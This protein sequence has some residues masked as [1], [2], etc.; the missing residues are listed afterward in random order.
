MSCAGLLQAI[1]QINASACPVLA[2]DIPSGSSADTGAAAAPSVLAD[3]TISFITA[4]TGLHTGAGVSCAGVRE[5]AALGVPEHMYVAQGIPLLDWNV[6]T[7][8]ALDANTYKH[9]QGHVVIAGGDMSMPGAVVMAS[10]AALRAG[11]GMVTAL[12]RKEHG[13]AV[14][15]RTPE[16][17]VQAFAEDPGVAPDQDDILQRADL[18]VLGPGLG[19]SAWSEA[20]YTRVEESGKPVLLDAD[21]LYWLALRGR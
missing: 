7:L 16:V 13:T 9:Q 1:E 18:V 12:T 8:P 10:E 2:I 11:A 21:G 14:V 4:K 15:A 5:F 20:L 19:R 6:A 17:M 3:V